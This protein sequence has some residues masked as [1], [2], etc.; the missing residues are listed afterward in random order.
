MSQQQPQTCITS[1][2]TQ[3][4]TY[5]VCVCV[6]VFMITVAVG[7]AAA[8]RSKSS[9]GERFGLD[10]KGE[11]WDL[12]WSWIRRLVPRSLKRWIWWRCYHLWISFWQA[13]TAVFTSICASLFLRA[14]SFCAV[15]LFWFIHRN[16]NRHVQKEQF[17]SERN[18]FHGNKWRIVWLQTGKVKSTKN[19]YENEVWKYGRL[20]RQTSCLH[21]PRY[22]LR[23]SSSVLKLVFMDTIRKWRA[24]AVLTSVLFEGKSSEKDVEQ[25]EEEFVVL[26]IA[27]VVLRRKRARKRVFSDFSQR[28]GNKRKR[29]C[30]SVK[31]K[32]PTHLFV[33]V[34]PSDFRR[35]VGF[36]L[37]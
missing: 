29:R 10:A 32:L 22:L 15:F 31:K 7:R 19:L 27:A 24:A 30:S 3:A 33:V 18:S 23:S 26:S 9:K 14:Y 28:Q 34:S 13:T 4:Q 20:F 35:V 17:S 6:C 2:P 25:E 11:S 5:N 1:A 21:R 37:R 12:V 36:P 8:A 16:R